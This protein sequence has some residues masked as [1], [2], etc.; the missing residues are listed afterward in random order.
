MAEKQ[1]KRVKGF[2]NN[3]V[4]W[5]GKTDWDTTYKTISIVDVVEKTG[6]GE[7]DFSIVKK[8]LV[9]ENPIVDVVQ[10]D[11]ESV[12]VENIMR[13]IMR[14]GDASL[15]PADKGNP[16]V[17]VVDAP[18]SLMELKALGQQAEE[19]FN[20]LPQDLTKGIDMKS[21]VDSF[22]QEQFDAF[23]KALSDKVKGDQG[24]E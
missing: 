6:E 5:K 16:F 14:T 21:F 24:N 22:T 19:K 9:E 4:E 18:Q 23:V 20:E 12:G 13:Q 11:A 10:A 2:S 7:Q 15:F 8:V 1:V 17:D 3:G